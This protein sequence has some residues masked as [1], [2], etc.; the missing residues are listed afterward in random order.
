MISLSQIPRPGRLIQGAN[1]LTPNRPPAWAGLQQQ[2]PSAGAYPQSPSARQGLLPGPEPRLQ[3][4]LRQLPGSRL[5]LVRIQLQLAPAAP[6]HLC[7]AC[8]PRGRH[9]EV[10]LDALPSGF[11]IQILG[12]WLQLIRARRG[13]GKPGIR[14][15]PAAR[16]RRG[17]VSPSPTQRA[18]APTSN[19]GAAPQPRA[20][21]QPRDEQLAPR[22][23]RPASAAQSTLQAVLR[24]DAAP[25]PRPPPFRPLGPPPPRLLQRV[26]A[27]NAELR[28]KRP[29]RVCRTE[30]S[31]ER[32]A[33]LPPPGFPHLSSSLPPSLASSL[34]LAPL[35]APAHGA[36]PIQNL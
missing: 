11:W 16:P 10:G 3:T 31:A 5:C 36:P 12:R 13:G 22:S 1:P 8:W 24:G 32:G 7:E 17:M 28:G 35:P 30:R 19:R 27:R 26:L 29:A 21:A 33:S 14:L 15:C 25:R 18:P 6:T 2:P 4:A 34:P 20:L 9:T 23:R